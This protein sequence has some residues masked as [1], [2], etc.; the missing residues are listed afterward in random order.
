MND[1]KQFDNITH[2]VAE[3]LRVQLDKGGKVSVA[4]AFFSDV[5][6]CLSLH[7]NPLRRYYDDLN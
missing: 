7:Q 5:E 3:D 1:I 2:T 6:A 4:V